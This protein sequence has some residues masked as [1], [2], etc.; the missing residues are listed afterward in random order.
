MV[1]P[2]SDASDSLARLLVGFEAGQGGFREGDAGSEMYIIE[3]GQVEIVR[4]YGPHERRLVLLEAG[5]FFGEMSVLED[6]PRSATARA[7][8]PS[9]LLAVDASTFDLMLRQNSE[10]A[11]RM[12][13]TLSHRLR[14]IEKVQ[15]EAA[16]VAHL[17]FEVPVG[18]P[19]APVVPP[20]PPAGA[21][22]AVGAATSRPRLV[23][24]LSGQEF[25]LNGDGETTVGRRDP[26]SDFVPDIDLGAVDTH[27]SLSRRHARFV[28]HGDLYLLREEIGVA[29]GTFVNGQRLETGVP[30]PLAD[31]D[32]LRFGLV[33][34]TLR[35]T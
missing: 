11:V 19:Q 2:A 9:K 20:A 28:R 5:D 1:N 35:L 13:R 32:E 12:L 23:H 27:R 21:R 34:L 3:E 16:R 7:L 26:V 14:Q 24:G 17:V 22:G 10:I 25:A 30:R 31:G 4:G 6:A 8:V 29:N 18:A 15:A 33:A